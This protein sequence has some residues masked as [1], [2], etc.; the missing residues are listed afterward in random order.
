MIS[1]NLC[2]KN[3]LQNRNPIYSSKGNQIGSVLGQHLHVFCHIPH[4][5]FHVH[6]SYY[7]QNVSLLLLT[8]IQGCIGCNKSLTATVVRT[9]FCTN[10]YKIMLKNA[11]SYTT[12]DPFGRW[13]TV[14]PNDYSKVHIL[15]PAQHKCEI[16]SHYFGSFQF[17]L[18]LSHHIQQQHT[19]LG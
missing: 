16:G 4:E 17:S 9:V 5:T 3:I 14:Y 15:F 13:S 7:Q 2:K 6:Q 10:V 1:Q 8:A 12:E 19:C 11:F 18:Y